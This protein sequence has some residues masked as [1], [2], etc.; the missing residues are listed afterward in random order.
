MNKSQIDILLTKYWDAE[1]SVA[2]ESQLTNY[3]N[4]DDIHHEHTQYKN[5]FQYFDLAAEQ[6]SLKQPEL[7][8]EILK[9]YDRKQSLIIRF[10]PLLKYAA[11]LI[12][13]IGAYQLFV[14]QYNFDT[15]D[16]QYAG[17]YTELTKE[18]DA[19]EAMEIT[20]EAL[21]FLSN[22]INRTEQTISDNFEPI[23]KAIRVIN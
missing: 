9:E 16:T 18:Q 5:L 12:I 8:E 13:L 10:K 22:K 7:S 19:E 6:Y 23:Q 4:S 2:E 20:L 17:K 21:S 14:N 3:F 15:L 1:T 11:T